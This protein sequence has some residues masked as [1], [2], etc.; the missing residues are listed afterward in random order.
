MRVTYDEEDNRPIWSLDTGFELDANV[1]SGIPQ[2]LLK[3]LWMQNDYI[4]KR[5]KH[6][7]NG[8]TFS[9]KSETKSEL[10]TKQDS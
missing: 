10:L 2:K 5:E 9:H 6:C 7:H 4:G 8:Y 1:L 3:P